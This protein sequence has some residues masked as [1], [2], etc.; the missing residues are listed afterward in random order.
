MSASYVE[1]ALPWIRVN[2]SLPQRVD[3][4]KG[5]AIGIPADGLFSAVN[6]ANPEALLMHLDHHLVQHTGIISARL[7]VRQVQSLVFARTSVFPYPEGYVLLDE[8]DEW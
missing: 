3:A 5:G 1:M 4:A 2:Q 8:D 6:R 7:S